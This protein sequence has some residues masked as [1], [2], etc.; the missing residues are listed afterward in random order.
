MPLDGKVGNSDFDMEELYAYKDVDEK[1]EVNKKYDTAVDE[2][3]RARKWGD[4]NDTMTI[5]ADKE[6]T[7]SKWE[8]EIET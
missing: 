2:K 7:V 1:K 6:E 5:D 4:P 3:N 8:Q